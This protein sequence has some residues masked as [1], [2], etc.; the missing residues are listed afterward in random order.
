MIAKQMIDQIKELSSYVS[1]KKIEKNYFDALE[2]LPVEELSMI[3]DSYLLEAQA[4]PSIYSLD[5]LNSPQ[6]QQKGSDILRIPGY[7]DKLPIFYY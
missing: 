5:Y 1:R 7:E 4:I 6:V 2:H 3:R